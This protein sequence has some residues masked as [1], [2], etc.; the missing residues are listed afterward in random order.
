MKRFAFAPAVALFLCS[1]VPGAA[2][3]QAQSAVARSGEPAASRAKFV[4]PIKG[5]AKIEVLPGESKYVGK[6]IVTTFKIKN[7][8]NA[9]IALL[10]LDEYWYDKG[11]KLVSSDT[12]R[13]AKPFSPG[14]IIEMTTRAPRLPG[15][16]RAQRVFS[17]AHG[18]VDAKPV[19]A[20]KEGA[21]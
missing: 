10:K 9:P 6:E 16:E 19:K 4:A 1:I 18:K 15:A 5:E 3:A 14:E 13:Y 17:H 12:Q 20:I 21:K 11:G 8:S 2:F 7:M